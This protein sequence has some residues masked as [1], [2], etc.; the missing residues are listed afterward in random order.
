VILV[1][2]VAT[3]ALNVL[4]YSVIPKGFFPQQDTGFLLGN[5]DGDQSISFREME[6]KMVAISD[7]VKRDP[8][9]NVISVSIGG[10][11]GGPVN[12]ARLYVVLKPMSER[13]ESAD[14]IIARLR[15]DT[16]KIT[17]ARLV[18]MSAQD[19]RIGGR[20]S[21]ALYQYTIQAEELS[22][23]N[24]WVPKIQTAMTALPELTDVNTDSQ[25][26]GLQ[27]YVTYDRDK[28]AAYG[29]SV[30][31]AN[32]TLYDAF[33]QQ[34]VATL[35]KS[36]NQYRLVMEV[37]AERTMSPESLRD[38]YVVTAGGKRVPLLAFAKFEP[39]NAPLNVNHQSQFVATTISFN[40]APGITLND[41]DAAIR[42]AMGELGV[43]S[44]VQG[45]FQGTAKMFQESLGNQ[46]LLIL[47]AILA[48]YVI[49]GILYESTIHPITILST[50]PSAGIG[51][52]LALMAFGMEFSII[53]LIGVL[54]LIGIVKKNAIMMI[55]FALDAE[56]N[57]KIPAREA[58]FTA[59]MLRFRPIMMTTMAAMFGALPLA[60]GF[61][62]G[63]E[64]RQPLGIAIVGG[65]LV[66]QLLTL[67]TTP[68][69]Y[70]YFDRL[71]GWLQSRRA[72]R[73]DVPLPAPQI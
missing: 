67:Y 54:L 48:M 22:K 68:V 36:L 14:V 64:L 63:A 24:E 11:R 50:L 32:R 12:S 59:C 38:I 41:A 51:A 7:I 55:D 25:N 8:A 18:L 42:V 39:A 37:N 56:R 21:A 27:T 66:S 72:I 16:A 44:S 62:E 53:A 10:S 6:S 20:S 13:T 26:R 15:Q 58:I 47:G 49:L 71:R 19:I 69:I 30:E 43:P 5:I 52:L 2:L 17:G 45:G 1:A 65:L 4:L 35:Y 3:V 9:V 70:L 23:L 34:P 28:M 73:T 61:G 60:I 46:P 33:G 31:V 40:L 57:E 29:I